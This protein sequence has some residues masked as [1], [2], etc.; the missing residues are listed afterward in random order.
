MFGVL[1]G[2]LVC[3]MWVCGVLIVVCVCIGIVGFF[4]GEVFS[5]FGCEGVV[6][7]NGWW[8]S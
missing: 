6:N 4:W 2:V 1:V 3:G 8:G 7:G 5:N